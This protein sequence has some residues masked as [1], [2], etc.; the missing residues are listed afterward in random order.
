[1]L[2][3]S[4]DPKY[5]SIPCVHLV[6]NLKTHEQVGNHPIQAHIL[7]MNYSNFKSRVQVL[8]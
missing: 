3:V 4:H 5:F 8:Q 2:E 1:M 6:K 7:M